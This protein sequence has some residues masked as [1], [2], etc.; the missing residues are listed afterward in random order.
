MNLNNSPAI[1]KVF[2]SFLLVYTFV[3]LSFKPISFTV[4]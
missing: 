4:F 2:S 1:D 3:Y